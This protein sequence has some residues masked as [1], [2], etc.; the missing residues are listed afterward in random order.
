MGYLQK[1][2]FK[3]A[4]KCA[5]ECPTSQSGFALVETLGSIEESRTARLERNHDEYRTLSSRT[6]TLLSRD[7]DWYVGDV[8]KDVEYHKNTNEL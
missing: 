4:K 2:N 7:K 6:R 8:A 1:R 3:V 5:G